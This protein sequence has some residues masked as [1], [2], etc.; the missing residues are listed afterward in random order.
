MARPRPLLETEGRLA[1]NIV[2]FTRALRKAGVKVGTAQV[3]DAVRAVEAA[4]FSR[5][6]DFYHILRAT[7]ITR[8]EQLELYHQVF[9]LFWRDP[10]YLERMI[11]MLSPTLRKEDDTPD[12]PKAGE[13]RAADALAAERERPAPQ[14]EKV[15][16]HIDASSSWSANE[17]LKAMD[18]EQM[19]AGEAAD[20]IAAIRTLH[21]PVP[22]LISRRRSPSPTGRLPDR[23]ATLRLAMRRGGELSALVRRSPRDRPPNLVALCDISGSMSVYSRMLLHFLH[24][25][26]WNRAPSHRAGW[27]KV[28]AFTFGT[29]LTNI[30]RALNTKDVD[31]ALAMIGHEAS[32]WQ[33]G[34]RIGSALERFNKDWSRRVLGQ[35]AVVLLIT[36]G[37]ERGDLH[38]LAIQAERLRKSCRSLIW[39][40]PL[41][42][43]DGFEPLAG[44][45]RTLLPHVDSLH[46]CHS[47][48]SLWDLVAALRHAAP[49]K[50]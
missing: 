13:R 8:P 29:R 42:R 3:E 11:H 4:G 44:G 6:T 7:L 27:G 20:A 19:S 33:G 45:A 49:A 32:D 12:R 37:L 38:Q 36:D 21:L 28:S 15:E 48:D 47:L 22:R 9:T 31:D 50:V 14:R 43:W 41:L 18:F 34:T 23:R 35:G 2:H 30:S 26:A 1:D 5:K 46:A 25:L 39:L 16:L 40:N 10:D 17:V 24:A